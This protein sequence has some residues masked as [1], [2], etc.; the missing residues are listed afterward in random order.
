MNSFFKFFRQNRPSI[1]ENLEE[2]P[3]SWKKIEYKKYP[4]MP[5]VKLPEPNLGDMTLGSAISRRESALNFSQNSISLEELSSILFFG[6]GITRRGKDENFH[7]RA[8]P[9]SGMRYPIEIYILALNIRGTENG[10][11]HYNVLDHSLE[12]L[13]ACDKSV[14]GLL[15]NSKLA[16]NA[17]TIL[18]FTM[19]HNRSRVKYGNQGFK[20][21]LIESGHIGENIYLASSA[22]GIKCRAFGGMKYDAAAELLDIDRKFEEPFYALALG[23]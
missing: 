2:W 9:S 5:S 12:Y 22:L 8:H 16:R 21:G 3:E 1:P 15:F 19:V 17:A 23:K 7:H 13:E 14:S 18:I 6:A 10:I 20:L 11:Y 4:R